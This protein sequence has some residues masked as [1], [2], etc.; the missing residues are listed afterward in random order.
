MRSSFSQGT[1]RQTAPVPMARASTTCFMVVGSPAGEYVSSALRMRSRLSTGAAYSVILS[2]LPA[3]RIVLQNTLLGTG[4]AS[5]RWEY[6][7][8]ATS[9]HSD[10]DRGRT[11]AT[12]ARD[13]KSSVAPSCYRR[14]A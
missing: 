11:L 9:G 10:S 2:P 3:L 6:Q 14:L 5:C 4:L 13:D 1:G 8:L 7:A 12:Y